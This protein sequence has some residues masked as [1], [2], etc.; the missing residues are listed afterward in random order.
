MADFF[1][2]KAAHLA[3]SPDGTPGKEGGYPGSRAY[4]GLV[5]HGFR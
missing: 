2:R 4:R 3:V 5:W 1:H